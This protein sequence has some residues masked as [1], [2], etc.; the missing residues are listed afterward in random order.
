MLESLP[1]W[2]FIAEELDSSEG[3][4]T[5]QKPVVRQLLEPTVWPLN[6]GKN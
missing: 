3:V 4:S 2:I 1:D 5:S 6:Q